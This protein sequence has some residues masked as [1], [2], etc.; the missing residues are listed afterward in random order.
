MKTNR[1]DFIK[2]MAAGIMGTGN[3]L[4]AIPGDPFVTHLR[5][6]AKRLIYLFMAGGP[7]QMETFDYKPG[8]RERFDQDLPDSIRMG[9]RG[10][11]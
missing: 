3:L 8:M 6:K 10:V 11:L 1:R 9:Q 5:P 4:S 2:T 7:S